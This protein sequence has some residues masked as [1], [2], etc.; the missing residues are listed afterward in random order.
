[1][2]NNLPVI[3]L[4]YIN[5]F[6]SIVISS[7]NRPSLGFKRGKKKNRFLMELGDSRK[8]WQQTIALDELSQPQN[9]CQYTQEE[10]LSRGAHPPWAMKEA[11][12]TGLDGLFNF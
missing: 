1:M 7:H 3:L 5:R 11:Q 12:V 10:L 9:S 8:E 4:K 6:Y 2:Q